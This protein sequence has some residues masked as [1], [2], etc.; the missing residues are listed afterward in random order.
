VEA[1][2]GLLGRDELAERVWKG[3]M[4][5]PETLSQRVLLLRRALGDDVDSSRYVRVVRGLGCQLVPPVR[6][7][8]HPH[9][10]PMPQAAAVDE[11]GDQAADI[12]LSLPAQP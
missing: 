8:R 7:H 5:T 10:R 3:R 9:A 6:V 12:D 2:P 11:A 1:A 4:L